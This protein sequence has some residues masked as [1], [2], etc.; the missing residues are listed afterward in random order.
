MPHELCR[1][2]APTSILIDVDRLT[3]A[4]FSKE[5]DLSDP[6]QLVSF[7]TSGHRGSSLAGSSTSRTSGHQQAICDWRKQRASRPLFLGKDTHALSRPAEQTALESW[8]QRCGH[9]DRPRR[10][11]HPHGPAISRLILTHNAA[12]RAAWPTA[13]WSAL[14]QSPATEASST[15][16]PRRP[17]R[18]QVTAW[19]QDRA[20]ALLRGNRSGSAAFP[21]SARA[22]RLH[23]KGRLRRPLRADLGSVVEWPPSATHAS[24]AVWT[25]W[26]APRWLLQAIA[27]HWKLDLQVVNPT[28]DRASL[29]DRDHDGKIRMDCSQPLCHGQTG[30]PARKLSVAFVMIRR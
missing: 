1:Q 13:S 24:S 3:N 9:C 15:T 22:P 19:I 4:Y 21:S 27:D 20:N 29:H 23:S 12:V 17:G 16:H 7:G 10:R 5:P 11:L 30:R 14:A 8:R 25:R 26:A 6:E 28:V 2:P 18:Y